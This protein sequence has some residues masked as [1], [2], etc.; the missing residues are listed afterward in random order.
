MVESNFRTVIYSIVF[1][2]SFLNKYY[3]YFTYRSNAWVHGRVP[4]TLTFQKEVAERM[5]AKIGSQERCRL[6]VMVQHL[7]YVEH[8]FTIPG[9]YFQLNLQLNFLE[10][11]KYIFKNLI[12][13]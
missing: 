10:R 3:I 4:M 2:A 13:R 8:K 1:I 11:L 12:Y 5:V 9:A 6:S 7:C